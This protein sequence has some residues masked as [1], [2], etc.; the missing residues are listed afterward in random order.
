M[1]DPDDKTPK[2]G[3]GDPEGETEDTAGAGLTG[4]D[5]LLRVS[6]SLADDILADLEAAE[7]TLD[8][9]TSQELDVITDEHLRS[10][11]SAD[12]T[13]DDDE[14]DPDALID[15]SD[16]DLTYFDIVWT[17]FRKNRVSY[18]ALWFVGF[19]FA[20]AIY[21]PAIS[22][23]RPY[24]WTTDEGTIYPWFS[25][26]FDRNFFENP[27]DIL[28]NMLLIVALPMLAFF[29]WRVKVIRNSGMPKRPRRRAMRTT[30]LRLVALIAV[31]YLGLLAFP[32]SDKY[33]LYPEME[34]ALLADGK[35]VSAVFP[36][37]RY[38]FRQIGFKSVDKPSKTHLLG[39]DQSTRDVATR[40][41]YGTRVSLTIGVVAVAIY[42]FIGIILGA[43]AG[44]FG[45]RVDLVIQRM[46]E[47]TMSVPTLFV[48]LTVMAFLENRSIFH[49]MLAIGLV[50]WTGIARL[51]RG[52][53]LRLRNLDFVTA[54]VALGYPRRRI[55]FEHILPNALGPVLISAAFGVASAILLE[56][57][58]SFLGLGD[59]TAP[60][61]G[62]ILQEGYATGAWHLI[63]APGFAI[64]L[65]VS[66]LNLAGDGLRDALDPK[67]RQ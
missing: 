4:T 53:F 7:G 56:S 5:S 23:D 60:S 47:I 36:P 46:I 9:A 19:L 37:S 44:Y 65:T 25:S 62:Q 20:L 55:I 16:E 18:G 54:A 57:T 41:L 34:A 42:L 61:W 29:L 43:T 12:I 14:D 51:V 32:T 38:T 1:A 40:L 3:D 66:A 2:N 45:G 33:V 58:L 50:R 48:I 10:I 31:G 28:F 35:D 64:F 22:S 11:V 63:L 30:G 24:I 59:L 49:I 21:A 15:D 6:S 52:E 8:E 39:T 67:L 26:L 17:Q 13:Q 27:V